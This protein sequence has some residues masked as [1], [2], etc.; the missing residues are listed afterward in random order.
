[1][2]RTCY[3]ISVLSAFTLFL[4]SLAGCSPAATSPHP[5]TK[6][7]VLDL[8][9]WNLEQKGPVA[10]NGE[11]QFY[12]KELRDAPASTPSHFF[13]VPYKWNGYEWNGQKLPAEGYATFIATIRLHPAETG[14]L[15]A[16]YIPDVYTAY[17]LLL[18][19][20]EL[21]VNGVVGT[22]KQTMRPYYMPRLVYFQPKTDTLVLTMQ[23]SN[24][25]HK[26]GGMWNEMLIGK[27]QT[28]TS[29]KDRSIIIQ[30]LLISSLFILGVYHLTIYIIR[31]KDVAS[32]YFG[33]FSF[34]L[35]IRATLQGNTF[36]FQL[37]PDFN[38][39]LSKKIEYGILFLGL[40]VLCMLIQSLYPQEINKRVVQI[41]QVICAFFACIV[42]VTPA[43]VYTQIASIYYIFVLITIAYLIYV[44]ILS[45]IR[46]R[47]FSYINCFVATFFMVTVA[48]D[49]LYYNQIIP[50]GNFTTL[51]LLLFTSVQSINLSI[52][53]A[54]GFS[55]VEQITEE[56][57]ELNETL[58]LRV[59]ER[60]RSLEHSMRE[61]AR[62]RA[63]MSVLEERSRI[64]GDIHDIVGHTLTTTVIQ[65][66]AGKR[67][68]E[69]DML[70]ALEK[71]ELSQELVRNGLNEIR[72]AIQIEQE[73]DE[74]FTF[75][76][77][78]YRLIAET[79]MHAGVTIDASISPLPFLTLSQKKFIY[80]ALQEGLT[81]GIRH[82]NSNHFIFNLERH[83]MLLHF[84]LRDNGMGTDD[85]QYGFGLTTMQ[86]RAKKING[87][88]TITSQPGKGCRLY[89]QLPVVQI[90]K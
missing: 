4:I 26:N 75:P 90:S 71:F 15:L 54:R 56:L 16:L 36:F 70:R 65:I 77:V 62:A 49:I 10:L 29:W 32:F 5:A 34:M 81:N 43:I 8:R 50:Y 61:V 44:L 69:K 20:Q 66:E 23:I 30:A 38:W 67:L 86:N 37:F 7:G 82:G 42:I 76:D 88:I 63:E 11:W 87:Q 18:N 46:K 41:T 57:K 79:E 35:G 89:I 17:R 33:L 74:H 19:G 39:E 58:E 68:I 9:S 60:T 84:T 83:G 25:V 51:G 22:S 12:W 72:R 1:M 53:F 24:F 13:M 85:I 78:L 47:P 48:L 31:R 64:A 59:Q 55:Q 73:D 52:T 27:A 40:P 45:V 80:H 2:R 6:Q 14:K 3:L 21:S 28:L